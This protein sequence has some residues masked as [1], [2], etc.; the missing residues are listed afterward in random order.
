[1]ESLP[2]L[3]SYFTRHARGRMRWRRI[4]KEEVRTVLAAP[5]RI[6]RMDGKLRLTKM[7]SGRSLLT[8]VAVESD[9]IIVITAMDRS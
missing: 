8:I 5:E 1:M 6:E 2:D 9:R 7:V 4:T 3:P